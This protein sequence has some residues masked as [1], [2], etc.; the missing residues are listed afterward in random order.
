[1]ERLRWFQDDTADFARTPAN[2]S[3][4]LNLAGKVIPAIKLTP[5]SSPCGQPRPSSSTWCMDSHQMSAGLIT[6]P[7]HPFGRADAMAKYSP[8]ESPLVP[9]YLNHGFRLHTAFHFTSPRM[10]MD[11]RAVLCTPL[12]LVPEVRVIILLHLKTY[13]LISVPCG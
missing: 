5:F 12:L 9:Q 1:M 13:S 6:M 10:G 8:L 7:Q 4:M 11:S 3:R 2:G